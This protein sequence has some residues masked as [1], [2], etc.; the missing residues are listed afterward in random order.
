VQADNVKLVRRIYEL[1]LAPGC[2]ADPA[3]REL[4]PRFFDPGVHLHQMSGFV[5]TAG[6]FDGYEG[7]VASTREFIGVFDGLGFIPE[8]IGQSGDQVAVAVRVVGSGR[9]SGAPLEE[10]VGHL[11]KLRDGRVVHWDVF[12]DPSEPFRLAGIA[13]P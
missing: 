3:T 1:I 13:T 8:R 11:F 2:L 5:D 9:R 7:L 10:R 6:E 4:L 12:D